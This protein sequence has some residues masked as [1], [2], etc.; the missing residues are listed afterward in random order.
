MGKY[1]GIDLGTTFSVVSYIDAKGNPV[2]IENDQGGY[3]TPSVVLFNGDEILVGAAAK[4]QSTR[5]PQNYESFVKRHMAERDYKFTTKEGESYNP[6]EVS[7]LILKKLKKNAEDK[8]GEPVDGAVITVPAYF[9]D[10]HR[11]ATKDAAKLAGIKVLDIINEPTAA[12]IAF[13][14]SKEIDK[15]QHVMIYD[16]GGGTFDTSV[17]EID[18]DNIRVIATNGDHNLGGYDIDK[19]LVEYVCGKAEQKKLDIRSNKKAMQKLWLAAEKAKITLSASKSAQIY[20]EFGDN[21]FLLD[22]T[23]EEFEELIDGTLDITMSIVQQTLDDVNL[24][25]SNMDKI[26]LVGG[27]T[28]IPRVREMIEEEAGFAP[29]SEVH[30]D[31]AVAIGAAYHA[32]DVAKK[33]ASGEVQN[34]SVAVDRGAEALPDLD[35]NYTFQDV[36]SHGVGIVI[37]NDVLEK[38]VNSIILKKN[39]PIPAEVTNNEYST[40][41]PYQSSFTLQITQGEKEDLD[42]V[43]IIG[44]ADI[45]LQ[46]RENLVPIGFT[47]SCDSSAII[48]VR[49]MDLDAGVNLGEVTINREKHNMTEAQMESASLKV[50]QLDIG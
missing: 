29:S 15:V 31:E 20:L 9:G 28:R 41:K 39:T 26:L 19:A 18:S 24:D 17:L 36:T 42:Y 30:P 50:N 23:R 25:Y 22:I 47:I 6:E 14:V 44:E 3:T 7:S 4:E 27:T 10:S 13:G 32:V 16:F 43:T 8:L 48:H 46:P 34:D 5:N 37:Y 2:L 45:K 49:A 12:A 11:Q 35:K 33:I 1:V 21:E 40:M 38:E